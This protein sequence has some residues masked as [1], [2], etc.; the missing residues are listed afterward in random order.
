MSSHLDPELLAIF[1]RIEPVF[2][3]IFNTYQD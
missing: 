3:N 2:E 1:L